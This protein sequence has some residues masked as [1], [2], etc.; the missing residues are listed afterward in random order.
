[1]FKLY[2][3]YIRY[4][5]TYIFIKQNVNNKKRTFKNYKKK[6]NKGFSNNFLTSDYNELVAKTHIYTLKWIII[7]IFK[8]SLIFS[9]ISQN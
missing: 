8:M 1:M 6:S 9:E 2:K 7:I 3:F 4:T 5:H